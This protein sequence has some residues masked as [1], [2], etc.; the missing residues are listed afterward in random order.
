MA[1]ALAIARYLLHLAA[2]GEEPELLTQMH[3]H[4]LL[5]YAQGWHLASYG[6]LLYAERLE[7]WQ[8]GPVVADVYPTFKRYTD[9]PIPG[10]EANDGSQ[11]TPIER[12]L[13]DAVWREYGQFTAWKL[14]EMTHSEPP[15]KQARRGIPDDQPSK[16]PITVDSMRSYFGTLHA[17]RSAKGGI[18]PALLRAGMQEAAEGRTLSWE[19]FKRSV[20]PGGRHG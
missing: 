3:V 13:L 9:G 8:H 11:L 14:R 10:S 20:S 16:Q 19:D 15:W 5:Y 7:A 6:K 1:N 18:D 17:S 4:K 12:C 2:R